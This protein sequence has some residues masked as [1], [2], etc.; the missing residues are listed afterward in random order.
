MEIS[1]E[2]IQSLLNKKIFIRQ[3]NIAINKEIRWIDTPPAVR[4]YT[5]I[6]SRYIYYKIVC[7]NDSFLLD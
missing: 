1:K 7:M 3:V 6:E 2:E 5:L 4:N